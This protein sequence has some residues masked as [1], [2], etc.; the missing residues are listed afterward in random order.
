M[1]NFKWS[2]NQFIINLKYFSHNRPKTNSDKCTGYSST[3][4][5]LQD[6]PDKNNQPKRVILLK[7]YK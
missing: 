3:N 4:Q 5:Q 7:H 2:I 6:M 1:F